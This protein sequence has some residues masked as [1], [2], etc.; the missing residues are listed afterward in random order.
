MQI[1]NY[2]G[3]KYKKFPNPS[4]AESWIQG[5]VGADVAR[6][7]ME[8]FLEMNPAFRSA[9]EASVQPA[10]KIPGAAPAPFAASGEFPSATS[11]SGDP[12]VPATTMAA[13]SSSNVIKPPPDGE[14]WIVYSD[15]SCQGNGKVGAVAGVGIWWG[16]DDPR[17]DFLDRLD[18]H[19]GS[20][21]H[22][23]LQEHMRA[24]PR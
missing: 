19:N 11:A 14:P 10:S 3:A 13:S 20:H 4:E 2:N 22:I 12:V 7:A 6:M 17:Y 15:G 23:P 18:A 9:I 24:M 8:S 5:N 1:L 21:A 16:K